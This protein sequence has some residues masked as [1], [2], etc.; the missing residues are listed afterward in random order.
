[1]T[2]AAAAI[3]KSEDGDTIP[4]RGVTARGR[5]TGLL[6]ELSVEQCYENTGDTNIEAV[7]TFP[8]PHHAVLLG[9][10]LEIGERKLS[11]V[12]TRKQAASRRYEEAIDE[13][14]TA[15]LLEQAGDGLYTLSLGN[16]LAGERAVIRYRY[17][18]LLDRHDDWVRLSIPTVIAPR[19]GE[20]ASHGLEAHQ[21][22]DVNLLASYP[23]ALSVDIIGAQ[24]AAALT[25]PSHR[26]LISDIED[27]RR[28]TLGAGAELDR[29]FIL[30]LSGAVTASASLTTRSGDGWVSLLSLAPQIDAAP[31]DALNLKLLVDCSGSMGGSSIAEARHALLAILGKLTPAD[32]V[33][34]TRFGSSVEHL[35]KGFSAATAPAIAQLSHAVREMDADLGGTELEGALQAAINIRVTQAGPKNIL[36]I[37]DGEVWA[38]EQLVDLAAGSGHRLFVVAVGAA[39]AEAL[40]RQLSEKTGGACEFVSPQEDVEGA[41]V[42]MFQRMRQQPHQLAELHWPVT[43]QWQAPL[44][45]MVFA[46]DT[47]HLLAGFS[48]PPVGEVAVTISG[49]ESAPLTQRVTVAET[50]DAELL[51]RVAAARRLS[52]LPEDEAAALAEAHQLVSR[53]TS[54]VVV[55]ERSEAEKAQGLPELRKVSQMLAAEWGATA[56]ACPQ[57]SLN[58]RFCSPARSP[59]PQAARRTFAEPSFESSNDLTASQNLRRL[60][61]SDDFDADVFDIEDADEDIQ[62]GGLYSIRFTPPTRTPAEVLQAIVESDGAIPWTFRQ[63]EHLGVPTQL[64]DSLRRFIKPGILS[65]LFTGTRRAE[66]ELVHTMIALLAKSCA[67][68]SLTE[69]ARTMLIGNVSG[70]RRYRQARADILDLLTTITA[71]SWGEFSVQPEFALTDAGRE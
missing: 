32:Q 55:Q 39:P 63:L 37:T 33:S 5:L 21:A 56:K 26:L 48:T 19:Y 31:V 67:G 15:C 22:P 1:M 11:G 13:G 40:A 46:G 36:L 49:A 54:F 71:D 45:A 25:S 38:V 61:D 68:A 62:S 35:G 10:D 28:V 29:D 42:R 23:F 53:F 59:T 6:F 52:A 4:L 9:L 64:I 18:E 2:N 30:Q 20:A 41:I 8:I 57:I 14:N 51:P 24:A 17:A 44:P 70:S 69:D 47:L 34:V 27:G 50:T 58:R 60:A 16:L 43:P 65:A 7:Y 66:A 12:A 3:L